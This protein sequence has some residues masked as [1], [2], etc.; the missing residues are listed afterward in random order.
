MDGQTV[1]PVPIFDFKHD[2][3]QHGGGAI[4]DGESY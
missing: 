1:D 4:K 3:Q 2:T